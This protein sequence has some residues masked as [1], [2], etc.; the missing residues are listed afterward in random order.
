[1]IAGGVYNSGLL[2]DPKPGARYNY[3]PVPEATLARAIAL[4]DRCAENGVPLK[5]AALQ[6]PLLHPAICSVVIG[7]ATPEEI[8]EN[9]AMSQ[10]PIPAELWKDLRESGLLDLEAPAP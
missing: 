2:A 10:V 8:A 6:M 1:M 5:A 7:A 9:V 4:R 3:A